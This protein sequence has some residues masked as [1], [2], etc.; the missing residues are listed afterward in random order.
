MS[1]KVTVTI[2]VTYDLSEGELAKW[3]LQQLDDHEDTS[4][5]REWFAI[6]RLIGHENLHNLDPAHNLIYE[7]N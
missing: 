6:D 1:K 2:T 3:Y 5:Q 4:S 7:E